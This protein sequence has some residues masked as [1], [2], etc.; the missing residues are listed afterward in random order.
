MVFTLV[1]VNDF[2][3]LS[4][5]DITNAKLTRSISKDRKNTWVDFPLALGQ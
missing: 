3:F 1:L 4:N 5:S 2:L